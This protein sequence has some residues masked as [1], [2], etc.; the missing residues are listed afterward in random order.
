MSKGQP[1]RG[2]QQDVVNKKKSHFCIDKAT[3]HGVKGKRLKAG[4]DANYLMNIL[5]I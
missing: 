3:K 2:E 5:N 1:R 4:W